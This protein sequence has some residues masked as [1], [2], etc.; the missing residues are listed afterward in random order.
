MVGAPRLRRVGCGFRCEFGDTSRCRGILRGAKD[1]AE[2]SLEGE[3]QGL[4]STHAPCTREGGAPRFTNRLILETSPYLLQHAHNPV[5]WYAWSDEAFERARREKK[6]VLLSIGYSTCHWCHVMERE[7]FEDLEIAQFMNEHFISIKVDREERPDVDAIYMNA[8]RSLSGRGGWPMT[9]VLTPDRQPFFGGTYFPPRDGARGSRKGFLTILRELSE[10]YAAD[11]ETLV[12]KARETTRKLQA[13]AARSRPG[14]IPGPEAIHDRARSLADSFDS[15]FGGFGRAPKFPRP[16]SYE[17]LLRYHRR[18]GDEQA[19][20]IVTKSLDAMAAGGIYDQVGGGFHR[21][22]T[23]KRWLVPHFEKMLYD[24]A[25]LVVLYLQAYQITGND[26]YAR[27]A[28]E[29][30]T[31][32]A[33]EMTAPG[34]A[35]YSATDADSPTPSGHEEEGYFFTWTPEELAAVLGAERA[36]IVGRYFRV[37]VKGNFEGRSILHTPVALDKIATELSI[38]PERLQTEIDAARPLLYGARSKRLPPLR[39]DKILTSWNGLMISAFAYGA[40]VLD[41][42]AFAKH[43]ER[44]ATF[45]LSNLRTREGRLM[46]TFMDG[47]ARHT[48]YLDDYAFL[49]QG[50]LDLYEATWDPGWLDSAIKLQGKLD[51]LYWD[52][53]RRRLLHDRVRS[54]GAPHP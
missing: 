28:R 32:V 12:A 10:Q 18:T 1:E 5:D 13:A 34:G 46:R 39:D 45:L 26:A 8:V 52:S 37:T 38:S 7:S 47:K 21:Y 50:L 48:A 16:S 54:R 42:P 25:Q 31:Y 14:D 30:L 33:R 9:S 2:R 40:L 51:A 43:A 20:A 17:V 3:G 49:A 11:P 6:P 27:V 19:L 24:N 44:A 41:D 29:T 15:Q 4:R 53:G 23:D 36:R 35:F 22:S